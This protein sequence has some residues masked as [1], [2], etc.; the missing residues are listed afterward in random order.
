MFAWNFTRSFVVAFG[1]PSAAFAAAVF[2]GVNGLL[3]FCTM[4]CWN[5][6]PHVHA[7]ASRGCGAAPAGVDGAVV[8]G[9]VAHPEV[10]GAAGGDIVVDPEPAA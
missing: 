5:L 10:G 8:G 4:Y 6:E 7:H 2:A 3:L 1:W 9:N